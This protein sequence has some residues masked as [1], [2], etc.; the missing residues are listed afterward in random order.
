[1]AADNLHLVA[2]LT[3]RARELTLF[4]EVTRILQDDDLESAGDWLDKITHA[5]Q[6]SWPHPGSIAV[7]SRL[8]AVEAATA[9]GRTVTPAHRAQ[10]VI[11]DGRT[12]AI[13][14]AYLEDGS[15]AAENPALR[16]LLDDVAEMFR[17]AVDRRLMMAALRQSEERY[18][19]VVEQQSDLVCRYL[20]DTTLTF[21]N[22]AYC[23]FFGKQ[24]DELIGRSFI[25]LIPEADRPAALKHI[26][27]L[28]AGG[29][30]RVY[31][32]NVLLP[33]GDTGRQQWI[34]QAIAS[35]DGQ[36]AELQGIGRDITD[37]WRAEEALRQKETKLREAYERIRSLAHRLIL[38]QEAERTQIAR[39][40]HDDVSQQL[41][42]LG[43]GLSLV[44]ARLKHS[45]TMRDEVTKLRH[46]ASGLAEKVR[47][48]SHALHPG[49]L[50]HAGLNAAIASHCEAVA[51]QHPFLVR[52][53]ARGTFND[54]PA[55]VAL[56]IYRAAQ[57]GL[58]N[59]AMHARATR[60]WVT[61]VRV[62]GQIELTV[63]D[64][65]RGFD[66][67]AA[68]ARGLGLLSI[69]ERVHLANGKFSV[70]ARPGGGSR[71]TVSVPVA[72]I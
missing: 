45:D 55:D 60:A 47:H 43:I 25:E 21:V 40:L 38:A 1:M 61:L 49:V 58:R 32:H 5:I 48:V 23:R 6:R 35:P 2:D 64:N 50:Q 44:E 51:A 56:C 70:T 42:A 52:F 33:N 17:T 28:L 4:H 16:T 8:G 3:I 9:G 14:V 26:R 22:D 11:T 72:W 36:I 30:P 62:G 54:V 12:G 13:E 67:A 53:E 7:W 24:R 15:G 59:V 19:S 69:E 66:P 39:E 65:G 27:A 29:D 71:L 10:F 41:A 63:T 20:P 18:R 57:Q 46:V 31:E 37:R 68:H 34:D